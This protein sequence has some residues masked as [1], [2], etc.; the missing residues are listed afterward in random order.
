MS[1]QDV[2]DARDSYER[3]RDLQEKEWADKATE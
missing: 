1:D 3:R 2:Q